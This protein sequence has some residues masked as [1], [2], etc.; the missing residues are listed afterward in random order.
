MKKYAWA[1]L[2]LIILAFLLTAWVLPSLPEQVAIHWNVK[3]EADGFAPGLIAAFLIPVMA[4]LLLGLFIALPRIDPLRKNYA[5]F[6]Q[7][8]EGFILIFTFFLVY[9]QAIVLALNLG[10][11]FNIIQ[12]LSPAFGLL[13]YYIGI[14]VS[15]AK[16]NWFV[17]IRTPWT[18][19][20]DTVWERTHQKGGKLFKTSGLIVLLGVILP[21]YAIWLILVPVLLTAAYT[22]VFSYFEYQRVA[23]KESR[24]K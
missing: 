18:L 20:N 7:Y 12:A 15:K 21:D 22:I 2:V 8:Y 5:R 11:A 23:G 6:Q 3:G 10:V 19:S 17:G 9:L 14:L 16:R 1:S 4:L 24:K 13:F